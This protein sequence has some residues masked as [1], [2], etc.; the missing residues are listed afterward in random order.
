MIQRKE[1]SH[2]HDFLIPSLLTP[3][4]ELLRFSF[5]LESL[6]RNTNMQQRVFP[7]FSSAKFVATSK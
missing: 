5:K 3:L 7:H 2:D 1:K 4:S 6:Q